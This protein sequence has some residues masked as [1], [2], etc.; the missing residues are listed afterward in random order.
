MS[1]TNLIPELRFPEFT[2]DWF[3]KTLSD[4]FTFKNG[5]NASKEDYGHGYK[6]INVLD[7]IQ[8]DFI[9]HDSI[10]GS[11]NV[12]EEEFQKNIVEYGDILFQRSSETREE[13][14]QANVYLDKNTP[15]TFGGFVIR[16]KGLVDYDPSF[17]NALLKT[18]RSRKEITSKSGG[19]TRYNVGQGTLSEVKIYTTNVEEQK[20]IATF[21]TAT[22]QRLQ[23]LQQKKAKLEDYKKGVM[24]QLFSQELRFKD[25]GGGDFPDW[26]EKKLGEMGEFKNG[27]NKSSD[28][29]GHGVPFINLMDVFGKTVIRNEKLGL[30]NASEKEIQQYSL[31][32]GD[33]IFIRSSVKRE[34]VGGTIVI[35]ADLKNTVYSGFLIRYRDDN[36]ISKEF[37]KYCFWTSSFRNQAI[38]MST[39][40]A[41]S[42]INQESLKVLKVRLPSFQEQQKIAT[43]L[44]SIDQSIEKLST[45]INQTMTFKKGLLQK[46]FV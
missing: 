43:F 24:Q 14:G 27:I 23:L 20:K 45:L 5:I 33:V 6:F 42:N 22:D 15:A 21:L 39:T 32:E 18:S 25:E 40:S 16:G 34:G 17:M 44:T 31:R 1:E 30:V 38:S 11:V 36:Y 4:L 9:T 26:E 29:F 10:I 12:S 46:M 8:N 41:N 37:K 3:E 19:S 13:V 28:D 35:D 7:I 2:E